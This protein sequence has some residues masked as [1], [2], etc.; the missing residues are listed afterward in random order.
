[1][2]NMKRKHK[3]NAEK[4]REKKRNY[5]TLMHLNVSL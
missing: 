3:G 2:E 4:L 5:S 1:M